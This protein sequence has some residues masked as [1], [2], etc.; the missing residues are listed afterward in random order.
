MNHQR[1]IPDAV[2]YGQRR[3]WDR[4]RQRMRATDERSIAQ[5]DPRV[6]AMSQTPSE[7]SVHFIRASEWCTWCSHRHTPVKGDWSLFQ[8]RGVL[9]CRCCCCA[10]E[11]ERVDRDCPCDSLNTNIF[12]RRTPF[13]LN[14]SIDAVAARLCG[15]TFAGTYHNDSRNDVRCSRGHG[16]G[17]Y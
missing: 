15:R 8:K 13:D 9:S 2:L 6:V 17:L 5:P 16:N 1:K 11:L 7:S 4:T 3:E 12:D 10:D 14:E